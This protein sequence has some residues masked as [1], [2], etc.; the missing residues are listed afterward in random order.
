MP[1]R[2]SP[3]PAE[4]SGA[5]H[6][7]HQST[8]DD[9]ETLL[10]GALELPVGYHGACWVDLEDDHLSV[11]PDAPIPL[12]V[13]LAEVSRISWAAHDI[14]ERHGTAYL[15]VVDAAQP[16]SGMRWHRDLTE[17][18]VRFT[19]A[20]SSDDYPVNLGFLR[21]DARGFVDRPCVGTPS[22]RFDQPANGDI[23][24]FR[25][26]PHGALPRV[27]NHGARTAVF[28]ATLWHTRDDVDLR[29]HCRPGETD[30]PALS[31][32]AERAH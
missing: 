15:R 27:V 31:Q 11:G 8:T 19:T 5:T 22:W 16:D 25:T 9:F 21:D 14:T 23:A 3:Y 32:L 13:F 26:E 28:F 24:V 20:V 29:C 30:H 7:M 18:G 4:T 17:G 6:M 1:D 12:V 10:K 2:R